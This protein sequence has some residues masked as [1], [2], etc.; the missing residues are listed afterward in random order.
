MDGAL[1]NRGLS[2]ARCAIFRTRGA[3]GQRWESTRTDTLRCR[4]LSLSSLVSPDTCS[5]LGCEKKLVARVHVESFVPG[6]HVPHHAVDA[7]VRRRMRVGHDELTD[8]VVGRFVTPALG[9]AKQETLVGGQ[10]VE[11]RRRL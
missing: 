8:R 4:R 3:L 9:V 11:H 6:I 5:V 2:A 7:V 1:P 10:T